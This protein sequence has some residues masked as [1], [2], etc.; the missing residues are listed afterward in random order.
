WLAGAKG[1]PGPL[2][3]SSPSQG[4]GT[5]SSASPSGGEEPHHLPSPLGEEG[6]VGNAGDTINEP[7]GSLAT[8]YS[9][10]GP[11][12]FR[13]VA[14]LGVQAPQPLEHA[15]AYGVVHR[16]IKPGNLMVDVHGQLWVTDF[17]LAQFQSETGLTLTGDL[18]GTLR[19]M[20]PEQALAKR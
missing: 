10:D 4:G 6:R 5:D 1:K 17:G 13:T 12:F 19:Y 7:V 3:L 18:L 8:A 9:T 15:H 16:D 11:R 20:S 2:T 14:Q